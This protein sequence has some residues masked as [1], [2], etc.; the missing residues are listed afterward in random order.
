MQEEVHRFAITYQKSLRNNGLKAS[1]LDNIEG[2]GENR[3]RELLLKFKTISNIKKAT[4]EE[5]CIVVPQNVAQNILDYYK[6]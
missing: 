2:V 5:L 6:K 4:F 1:S 3:R